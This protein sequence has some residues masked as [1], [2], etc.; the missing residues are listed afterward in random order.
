MLLGVVEGNG[1]LQVVSGW[2]KLSQEDTRSSPAHSGLPGGELGLVVL[3]Q[4][5]GAAPPT[6]APSVI[7]PA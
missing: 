6:P 7:L 3:G 2:D 1:L 5:A 4:S